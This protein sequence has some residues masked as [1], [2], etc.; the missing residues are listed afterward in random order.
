MKAKILLLG[1]IAFALTPTIAAA[2]LTP[3]PG[4]G[5]YN[6]TGYNHMNSGNAFGQPGDTCQEIIAAGGS[7]PGNAGSA[8]GSGS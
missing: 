3:A 4:N 6:G 8:P 7:S 5:Q 2:Q 1:A